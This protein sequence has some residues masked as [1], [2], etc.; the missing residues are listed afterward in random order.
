MSDLEKAAR[1][2]RDGTSIVMD[3][4]RDLLIQALLK[5]FKDTKRFNV[6]ENAIVEEIQDILNNGVVKSFRLSGTQGIEE[7]NDRRAAIQGARTRVVTLNQ[8][9]RAIRVA[10]KRSLRVGTVYIRQQ[11]AMK[12]L[13]AKATDDVASLVLAEISESLETVERLLAE[14]AEALSHLDEGTR[15]VDSWFALHKQYT[16]MTGMRGAPRGDEEEQSPQRKLGRP[17]T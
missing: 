10:A 17:R 15:Y 16:F 9:L 8:E 12:G 3:L 5:S 14:T 4:R 7:A 1:A 13:Q 6:D 2:L 11:P